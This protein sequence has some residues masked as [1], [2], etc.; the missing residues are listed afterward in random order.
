VEGYSARGRRHDLELRREKWLRFLF[1]HQGA[2]GEDRRF[3]PAERIGKGDLIYLGEFRLGRRE[4]VQHLT[5]IGKK[6][7]A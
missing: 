5:V 4:T 7:Q 6:E 2:G 3:V 1:E